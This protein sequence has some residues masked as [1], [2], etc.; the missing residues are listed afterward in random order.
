MLNTV[1]DTVATQHSLA[2]SLTPHPL[3]VGEGINPKESYLTILR[4]AT[5]LL[6]F[7]NSWG[8]AL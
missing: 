5:C 3:R 7:A 1:S 4:V 8:K 2:V 6:T